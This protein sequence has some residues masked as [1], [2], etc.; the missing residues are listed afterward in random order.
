MNGENDPYNLNRFVQA[1]MNVYAQV[2]KELAAGRKETH[3]MWFI[4]PQLDGLGS[5]AISRRF[6]IKSLAEARAYLNHPILGKRLR[7]STEQVVRLSDRPVGDIFGFPDDRKFHSSMTLFSKATSDNGVFLQA[8]Q[9][10]FASH[11]DEKTLEGL[12]R[13]AT[14]D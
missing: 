14:N 3:W 4:F 8:L 12:K 11:V 10:H 1:Q 5:S 13:L 9:Q 2:Q 7:E 6:A